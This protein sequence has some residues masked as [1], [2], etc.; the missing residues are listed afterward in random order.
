MGKFPKLRSTQHPEKYLLGAD[1]IVAYLLGVFG[2]QPVSAEEMGTLLLI[3]A[4]E[5]GK[6][7]RMDRTQILTIHALYSW[8]I[9][10]QPMYII[11][12]DLAW[13]LIN[14]RPPITEFDL[15]PKVPVSGMYVVIPPCFSIYNTQSGEHKIEGFYLTENLVL[16]HADPARRR[17]NVKREDVLDL[18][19]YVQ[20]AGITVVA[21]GEDKQAAYASKN[22]L[23]PQDDALFSFHLLPGEP[24]K[25]EN[26]TQEQLGYQELVYMVTNL[27][28]LLQRTKGQITEIREDFVPS[29]RG[30]DRKSRRERERENAKGRSV[31][32]H[33]IL[34][35]SEKAKASQKTSGAKNGAE[36]DIARHIVAGHIH[37]YWV[38]NPEDQPVLA[39]KG[40][41]GKQLHL[42]HKWLLPYWRGSGEQT[43]GK[44]V[45]VKR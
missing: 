42:I 44:T 5:Q 27:L 34:R 37:S 2:G 23:A 45:V 14:T 21:V 13:A 41:E 28:Y 4:E 8:L 16:C 9:H 32:A 17:E 3:I 20:E 26:V 24:L 31:L 1:R 39:V 29:L 40:E 6:G 7:D 43:A 15:L 30:D 19:D 10:N 11:D 22:K 36:K 38:S 18:D 25:L 35:L 12:E 33:T